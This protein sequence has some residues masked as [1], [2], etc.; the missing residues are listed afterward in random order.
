MGLPKRKRLQQIR[1]AV[2]SGKT[3]IPQEDV[4]F[5]NEDKERMKKHREKTKRNTRKHLGSIE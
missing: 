2:K 1:A 3:D 4:E 5:L